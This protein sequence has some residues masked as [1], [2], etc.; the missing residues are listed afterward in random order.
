MRIEWQHTRCRIGRQVVA[1]A[2][3]VD[4]PYEGVIDADDFPRS[5]RLTSCALSACHSLSYTTCTALRQD[6]D[7]LCIDDSKFQIDDSTLQIGDST[8]RIGDSTL[9][10]G[11]S[12][13]RI[14]DLTLLRASSNRRLDVRTRWIVDLTDLPPCRRSISTIRNFKSAIR[15][16]KSTIR[17]VPQWHASV[18]PAYRSV[19]PSTRS[20]KPKHTTCDTRTARWMWRGR[21]A[22]M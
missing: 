19:I 22:L 4:T 20:R 14:G 15:S 12:R 13:L 18:T 5:D 17:N 16:F 10:I 7:K 9:Q 3:V 6:G 21:P 2:P 11:D 8:L 1:Y